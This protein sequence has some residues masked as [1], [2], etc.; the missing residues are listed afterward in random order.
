MSM[1]SAPSAAMRLPCAIASVGSRK[2]PPSENESGVTL[3]I[4][5]TN[6]RPSANRRASHDCGASPR[7]RSIWLEWPAIVMTVACAAPPHRVKR[8]PL[9]RRLGA[10]TDLS[11]GDLGGQRPGLLDPAHDQL[12]GGQETD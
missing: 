4:P 7:A 6:G 10:A 2:R 12:L 1:M 9:P 8:R 5:M 11:I 3:R